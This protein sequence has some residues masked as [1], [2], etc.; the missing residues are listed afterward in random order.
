M[1]VHKSENGP[2]AFVQHLDAGDPHGVMSLYEPGSI[3]RIAALEVTTW[4]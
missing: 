1:S 2:R 4:T 3:T